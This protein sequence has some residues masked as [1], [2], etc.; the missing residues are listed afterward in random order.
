MYLPKYPLLRDRDRVLP[1]MSL[2]YDS[3]C[4]CELRA[5]CVQKG[6]RR[7]GGGGCTPAGCAPWP[8]QPRMQS[9]DRGRSL[10]AV[11]DE[12]RRNERKTRCVG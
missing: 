2:R 6:R 8:L 4:Q 10:L 1:N 3:G 9:T 11:R 7:R 5:S 12:T